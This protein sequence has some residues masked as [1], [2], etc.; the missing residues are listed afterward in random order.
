MKTLPDES[1][2]R[3]IRCE[4]VFATADKQVL[5]SLQ[6]PAGTTAIEAV[7]QSGIESEF[8]DHDITQPDLGVFAQPVEHDY[9]VEDGDRLEI[10]RPLLADPKEV[11]RL[12]AAEGLTMGKRG[13]Q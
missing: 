3:L 4:V 8:P 6:V 10:Y 5:L 13:G 9:L 12:L 1:V 11:R 7:R 2:S